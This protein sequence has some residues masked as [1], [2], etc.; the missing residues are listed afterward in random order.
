M[1]SKNRV[2]KTE[3]NAIEAKKEQLENRIIENL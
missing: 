3:F 1:R 2:N